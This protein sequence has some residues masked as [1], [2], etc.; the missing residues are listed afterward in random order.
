MDLNQ[1]AD[2]ADKVMEVAVPTVAAISEDHRDRNSEVQ[3]LKA[4]VSRLA[5]LPTPPKPILGADF[6][7]HYGLMVDLQKGKLVDTNTHI[8]V[9]GILAA[10]I[11][12]NTSLCP[13]DTPNPY[14]N[15]LAQF[16]A[17]TQVSAH[18][19]PVK[20]DITHHIETLGPHDLAD[21]HLTD[22]KP[23]R[24]NSIT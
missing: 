4:E 5:D 14:L 23:P 10:G 2:M 3:Q 17:L 18:H 22:Y 1:L 13:K 21:W 9:Q 15:L 19:T 24:G 20:H 8:L 16:L 6:L 11:S 12:P 7:R